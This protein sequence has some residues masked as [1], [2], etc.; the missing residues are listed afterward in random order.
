MTVKPG[1]LPVACPST[2]WGPRS[3]WGGSGV[4][5]VGALLA[6]ICLVGTPIAGIT[7]VLRLI[8]MARGAR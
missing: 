2:R 3:G 5:A 4:L 7:L 8:G 1:L 6:A